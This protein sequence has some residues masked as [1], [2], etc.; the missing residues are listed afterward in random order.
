MDQ[1]SAIRF[2]SQSGHI[3]VVKLLLADRRLDPNVDQTIRQNNDAIWRT[4]R[5]AIWLASREQASS[6]AASDDVTVTIE[7]ADKK[8]VGEDAETDDRE[9]ECV[10]CQTN[11]KRC[12]VHPC[13]HRCLCI[14]C[15]NELLA[16]SEKAKC[17][18]CRGEAEGFLKIYD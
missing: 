11:E 15:A 8:I 2:A 14:G 3:E 18:M 1:D 17:P 9:K 7:I 12:A 10:V 6:P 13:G 16:R 5:D 4:S